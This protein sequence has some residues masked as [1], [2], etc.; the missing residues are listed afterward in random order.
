MAN[1]LQIKRSTTAA[2]APTLAAGEL[3]V[4][5]ADQKLWL[6][7]GTN[8][9]GLGGGSVCPTDI[10]GSGA[11]DVGDILEMISQWGPC[12]GC[13]GD[14][15]GNGYVDVSDLLEVIGAWGPCQ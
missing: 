11:T 10:D 6:G 7:D 4:N 2:A 9:Y 15:D 13:S 3:G 1:T 12:S 14:L 5:I 8:N